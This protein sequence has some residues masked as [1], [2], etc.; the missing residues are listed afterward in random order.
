MAYLNKEEIFED[1]EVLLK[2]A[3]QA[4]NNLLKHHFLDDQETD[5]EK[6]F[7]IKSSARFVLDDIEQH[8][9]QLK[10]YNKK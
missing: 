5:T 6:D 10:K 1:Q 2:A 9:S 3:Y 4:L 7:D 8:Y